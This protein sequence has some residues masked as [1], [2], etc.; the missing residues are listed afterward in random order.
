MVGIIFAKKKTHR[1]TK[2]EGNMVK[3]WVGA[4]Y[5]EKKTTIAEMWSGVFSKKKKYVD[6]KLHRKRERE[7]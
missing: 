7:R 5:D 4:L 2:T 3:L 1:Q 6:T